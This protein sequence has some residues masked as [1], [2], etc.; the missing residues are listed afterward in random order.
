VPE[1]PPLDV[2]LVRQVQR[3]LEAQ[4]G[5]RVGHR[6]APLG[7]REQADRQVRSQRAEH[8]GGLAAGAAP[9]PQD[10]RRPDGRKA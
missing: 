2:L 10:R 1:D 9:V 7:A 3:P 6:Q 8:H 4:D 5:P